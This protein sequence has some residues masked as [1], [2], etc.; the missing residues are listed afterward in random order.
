MIVC[1]QLSVHFLFCILIQVKECYK[2][3]EIQFCQLLVLAL[4]SSYFNVEYLKEDY[5]GK[6]D[7]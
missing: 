2:I 6:Q 1:D 3:S 7:I 4:S 5:T